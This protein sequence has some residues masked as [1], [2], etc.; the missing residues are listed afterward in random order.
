MTGNVVPDIVNP[1]PVVVA[2]LMVTGAVPTDVK[3]KAW[4]ADVFTWTEPKAKLVELMLR[5]GVPAFG[6]SPECALLRTKKAWHPERAT[7]QIVI[8]S[9]LEQQRP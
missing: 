3:V 2:V 7:L 5:A 1:W 8:A 4:V 9:K 6:D